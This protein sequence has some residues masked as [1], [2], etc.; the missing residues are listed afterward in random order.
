MKYT[1]SSTRRIHTVE[2][3]REEL[4]NYLETKAGITIPSNAE[5]RF[6]GGILTAQ[7]SSLTAK[8]EVESL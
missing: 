5:V 1:K 7:W 6:S 4:M 2:V 8:T 3:E